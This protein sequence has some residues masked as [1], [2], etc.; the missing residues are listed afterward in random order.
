M[1]HF[2]PRTCVCVSNSIQVHVQVQVHVQIQVSSLKEIHPFMF[3]SGQTHII[4]STLSLT[5]MTEPEGFE[6]VSGMRTG[7]YIQ[8][9]S[10]F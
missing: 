9:N 4:Q 5:L 6:Y 8:C 3:L 2:I 10:R 1:L 7:Q